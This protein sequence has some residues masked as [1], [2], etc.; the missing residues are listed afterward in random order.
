M[1]L[2]HHGKCDICGKEDLP[3]ANVACLDGF[4]YGVTSTGKL[5]SVGVG[6]RT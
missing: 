5:A 6:G 1:Y 3:L 2:L 4:T